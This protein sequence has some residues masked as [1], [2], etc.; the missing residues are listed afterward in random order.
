MSSCRGC[1]ALTS[2]GSRAGP[3]GLGHPRAGRSPAHLLPAQAKD[4]MKGLPE[5]EKKDFASILTNA[6]PL[7]RAGP[8]GR[9]AVPSAQP[10][11]LSPQL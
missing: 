5:L 10:N 2:V 7:G 9:G 1:R 11:T 4:Y 8:G 6:S 3:E